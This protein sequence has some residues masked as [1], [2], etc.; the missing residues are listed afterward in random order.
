M[1]KSKQINECFTTLC[2]EPQTLKI[3]SSLP[4]DLSSFEEL[5]KSFQFIINPTLKNKYQTLKINSFIS[6]VINGCEFLIRKIDNVSSPNDS[7]CWRV[8]C[9]P[10]SVIFYKSKIRLIH[11]FNFDEIIQNIDTITELQKMINS[12]IQNFM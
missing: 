1:K 9:D 4:K 2:K 3:I 12:G 7:Y 6:V 11:Q 10:I 5:D 8:D